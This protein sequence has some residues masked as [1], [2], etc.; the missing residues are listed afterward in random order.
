L[1]KSNQTQPQQ[2]Q[3]K[4]Q[5]QQNVNNIN[6]VTQFTKRWE[7]EK[8]E[9]NSLPTNDIKIRNT[10]SGEAKVIKRPRWPRIPPIDQ[11]GYEKWFSRISDPITGE[12]Y[13]ERDLQ[14]NIIEPSDGGPR[15]RYI[16]H[17]IVRVKSYSG[18]E[19]L[20]SSGMLVGFSSLGSPVDYPIGRP[21]TYMKTHWHKERDYNKNTGRMEEII[22]SP[23]GQQEI[24]LLPFSAEAVEELFSH[25]IKPDT[26]PVYLR[27][28]NKFTF[29]KPC[30]FVV[31][32]ERQNT[33]IAVE[34]SNINKTKELFSN[35]S[36]SYLF[37]SEYIP[38][39]L[40]REI[41]ARSEGITGEK[42][43]D[44]PKIQDNS[45]TISNN[46]PNTSAYT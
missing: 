21:E 42:I 28:R 38:E 32:E 23:S 46:S 18:Q 10:E 35:K 5:Q 15:A 4:S 30:N 26:P 33:S 27:A 37:N 9:W 3:P 13:P 36:F 20:F 41:R 11:I 24:Y 22:K 43:Q 8:K 1:N 12:F 2:Q 6:Q 16:I 44:S 25:T 17:N 34:W 19:Y 45:S 31:K 14:G 7:I 29:D 39:P 40:K